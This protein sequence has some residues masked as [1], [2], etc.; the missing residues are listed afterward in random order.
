MVPNVT[1]SSPSALAAAMFPISRDTVEEASERRPSQ[2]RNLEE[3]FGSNFVE[4]VLPIV[5]TATFRKASSGNRAVPCSAVS[6][7]LLLTGNTIWLTHPC[8][9]AVIVEIDGMMLDRYDSQ[10]QIGYRCLSQRGAG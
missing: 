10:P 3:V 5:P 7:W 6:S 9:L 8:M 2:K 4:T 1:S